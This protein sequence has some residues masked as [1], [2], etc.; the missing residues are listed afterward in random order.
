[1]VEANHVAD[2]HFHDTEGDD[3]P[4]PWT[5]LTTQDE[6]GIDV[7]DVDDDDSYNK[8]VKIICDEDHF[9]HFDTTN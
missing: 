3:S 9:I 5:I 6:C 1:M 7:D 2:I 8:W 4:D